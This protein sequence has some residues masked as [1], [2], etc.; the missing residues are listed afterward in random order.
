MKKAGIIPAFPSI[1]SGLLLGI[2]LL[3]LAFLGFAFLGRRLQAAAHELLAVVAFQ[4]LVCGLGVAFLHALLLLL[5][6]RGLLFL[7]R[8]L[9]RLL[10][11]RAGLLVLVLRDGGHTRHCEQR[12]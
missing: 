12:G 1:G 5:L 10:R 6:R 8:I 7:G 11:L 4:P 2:G 9:H 3:R